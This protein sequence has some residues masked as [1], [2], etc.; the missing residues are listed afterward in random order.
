MSRSSAAFRT[1]LPP[2][3]A[4]TVPRRPSRRSRGRGCATPSPSGRRR[5]SRPTPTPLARLLPDPAVDGRRTAST[6]MCGRRHAGPRGRRLPVHGL[7]PRRRADPR[8]LGGPGLRRRPLRPRRRGAVSVNYRLGV[9]GYGLFPDAPANRGLL[10]QLAALEWVR[11]AIA[12]FGGD[13]DRVTVSGES[14]GA[15]SIGALLATPARAGLFRRAVLQSGRARR[16]QPG[17]PRAATAG[18]WPAAE[19]PRHRRGLRRRGP[20][21]AAGRGA[22]RGAAGGSP[23]LGGNAFGIVVDGD[24]ADPRPAEA[25]LDGLGGGRGRPAAGTDQRGVPA[26]ARP[27]RP[28]RTHRPARPASPWPE[29]GPLPLRPRRPA[30]QPPRRH[31]GRTSDLV[32][33]R[34]RPLLRVPLHRLADARA[35]APAST[36]VYEFAW[37]S[38]RTAASAPV[39]PWSWASSSTR[40]TARHGEARRT[41]RPAGAGRRDA[42]GLGG[43]RGDGDP[44][45]P[46]WDASHPVRVFG[47]GPRRS[48]TPRATTSCGAGSRTGSGVRA[49]S[50]SSAGRG[51][52]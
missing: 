5:P 52:R 36:Y 28:D 38:N 8:L 37:P 40:S 48:S 3:G 2:F 46:A 31:P 23:L 27:R 42:R 30:R 15:I 34:H 19:R 11:D 22:D 41:G 45:W 12:G 9:E 10:D 21:G 43:V 39:M 20:R 4:R 33:P 17:T 44:G 18:G 14:A 35:D 1:R 16:P 32:G 26:L 13:P 6:S 50:R 7:D 51:P 25:L 49:A 24:L 29:Q 47:P